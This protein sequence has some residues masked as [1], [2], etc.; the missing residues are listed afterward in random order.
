M[1][2]SD[3]KWDA[4][5]RFFSGLWSE[6]EELDKL[7]EKSIVISLSEGEITKIFTKKRIELVRVIKERNPASMGE[8]AELVMRDLTAVVR[9]L[10][11]L[12][13]FGIVELEKKGRIVKPRVEKELLILPL[14]PLEPITVADL[15]KHTGKAKT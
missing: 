10:K 5:M 2:M 1:K 6:P 14:G 9:D 4:I 15:E 11:I 13:E 12:K 7:P 8:L 3:E